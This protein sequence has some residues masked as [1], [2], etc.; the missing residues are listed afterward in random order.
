M[1]RLPLA[2]AACLLAACG[3]K[4]MVTT[5]DGKTIDAARLSQADSDAL[6]LGR[7]LFVL[8]DRAHEF[9]A[10]HRGRPPKGMRDLGVDSLTP[11]I[12]RAIAATDSLRIRVSYRKPDAHALSTCHASLGVL[13][14]ADLGGGTFTMLCRTVA[15]ADTSV[16]SRASR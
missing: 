13:E 2:L 4:E 15:G 9:A 3:K 7:D 1:R 8:A 5:G 12:A 11:E 14:E 6:Q 10:S 16:K